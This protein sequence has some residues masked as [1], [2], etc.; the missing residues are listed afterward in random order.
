MYELVIDQL[1]VAGYKQYEVSNFAQPSMTCRHN[2]AYWDCRAWEA[3]GPGA[4]RFDGRKEQQSEKRERL[5]K[6]IT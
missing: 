5:D 1:A 4:A 3:F 2:E 6:K